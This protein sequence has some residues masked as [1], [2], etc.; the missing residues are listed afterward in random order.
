[1]LSVTFKAQG[2]H[3]ASRRHVVFNTPPQTSDSIGGGH[4]KRGGMGLVASGPAVGGHED[5]AG[6]DIRN[7]GVYRRPA[8]APRPGGAGP[9]GGSGLLPLR[10]GPGARALGGKGVCPYCGS[11]LFGTTLVLYQFLIEG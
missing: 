11:A 6:A 10:Q 1:M 2:C 3:L 9:R 4:P 7:P 8:L 5:A